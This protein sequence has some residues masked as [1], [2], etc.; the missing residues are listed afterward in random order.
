MVTVRDDPLATQGSAT[1]TQR[2]ENLMWRMIAYSRTSNA[3]LPVTAERAVFNNPS[4][5]CAWAGDA[6]NMSSPYPVDGDFRTVLRH[7]RTMALHLASLGRRGT[8]GNEGEEH[9]VK[10]RQ[11]LELSDSALAATM[12][13]ETV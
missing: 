3:S 12:D 6:Q 2:T 13:D 5:N 10:A 1:D 8:K 4:G 7:S 9:P 11:R